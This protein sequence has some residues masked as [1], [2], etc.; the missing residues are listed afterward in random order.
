[1]THKY[2]NNAREFHKQA[3]YPVRR[4]MAA[5][6]DALAKLGIQQHWDGKTLPLSAVM[7]Q[8]ELG[9]CEDERNDV[10]RTQHLTTSLPV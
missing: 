7:A 9:E 5:V 8:S 6:L 3:Y 10:A 1:V 2:G 4:S